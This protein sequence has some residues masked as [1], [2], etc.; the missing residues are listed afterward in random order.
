MKWVWLKKKFLSRRNR[1]EEYTN[2]DFSRNAISVWGDLVYLYVSKCGLHRE[3]INVAEVGRFVGFL[4]VHNLNRRQYYTKLTSEQE[5]QIGLAIYLKI[6]YLYK[7]EVNVSDEI[8]GYIDRFKE[9]S[10]LWIAYQYSKDMSSV[11]KKTLKEF[12]FDGGVG[13]VNALDVSDFNNALHNAIIKI[14]SHCD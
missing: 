7:S 11:L 12:I 13:M 14:S 5:F 10:K 3:S 4:V 6:C 1:L 2:G 9:Y 8:A